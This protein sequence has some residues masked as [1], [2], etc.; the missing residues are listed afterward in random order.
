MIIV[1]LFLLALPKGRGGL[2]AFGPVRS[3]LVVAI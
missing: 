3:S 2:A 1:P